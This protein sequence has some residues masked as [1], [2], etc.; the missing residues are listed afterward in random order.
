MRLEKHRREIHL[1]T[2]SK[3]VILWRA[4]MPQKGGLTDIDVKLVAL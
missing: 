2:A 1:K 4:M 3:S